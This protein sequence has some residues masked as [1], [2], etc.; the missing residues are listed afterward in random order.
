MFKQRDFMFEYLQAKDRKEAIMIRKRE[1]RISRVQREEANTNAQ[2]RI[3]K[4]N[5]KSFEGERSS[6]GGNRKAGNALSKT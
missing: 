3:G 1:L 5:R 4:P 6:A 2:K